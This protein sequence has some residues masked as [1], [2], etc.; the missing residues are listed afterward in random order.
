MSQVKEFNASNPLELGADI[1]VGKDTVAKVTLTDA[2]NKSVSVED[3][4]HHAEIDAMRGIMFKKDIQTSEESGEKTTTAKFFLSEDARAGD[5]VE[6][7]YTDPNDH[8][9]TKTTEYEI[10]AGDISKGFF[11]QSLDI[12]ARSS[13]GYNLK[14]EAT[15]K[16][17]PGDLYSKTYETDQSFHINANSY[18]I[19][20]DASKTMKG[21][22]S[23]NDTLVVDG[24]TIDFSGVHDLDAKVEKFENIQLKGSSKITINAQDVLDITD[25]NKV[26]NIKGSIDDQG[27]KTT[28][29]KLDGDWKENTPAGV[30][31]YKT[32][33]SEDV[34]GHTIQIKIDDTVHIL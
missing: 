13:A 34:S 18:T 32:Y 23:D 22:D 6:I 17:N 30:T 27:N 31:D 9:Q 2:F 19:K 25:S 3:T 7:K 28:S 5:K 1:A 26:L 15:L 12:D 11:E 20:Y 24:Q 16:T 29:V 14:V 10:K 8:S 4:A 21:G 33:S